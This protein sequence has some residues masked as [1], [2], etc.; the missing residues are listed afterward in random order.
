MA[1]YPFQC[2]KCDIEFE[3]TSKMSEYSVP[4]KCPNCKSKKIVRIYTPSRTFVYLGDNE[5]TLG[6]L[7]G[8]N[9][10]RF[11]SDYKQHLYIKHNDYKINKKPGK[12]LKSGLKWKNPT[13]FEQ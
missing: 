6:H 9:R 13:K 11:S 3:I 1:T 4:K 5:I 2:E 8:R 7:G 10:D 12:P